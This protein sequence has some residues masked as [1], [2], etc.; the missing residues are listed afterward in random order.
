MVFK[1]MNGYDN[2]GLTKGSLMIRQ[3]AK[4]TGY[5]KEFIYLSS[6]LMC[7]ILWLL[8]QFWSILMVCNFVTTQSAAQHFKV[9]A[10]QTL[11]M[12]G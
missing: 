7:H 11:E 10:Q 6:L 8:C 4:K 12:E 1:D 9:T 3:V 5:K 2:T